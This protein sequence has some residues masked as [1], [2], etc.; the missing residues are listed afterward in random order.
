MRWHVQ[1]KVLRSICN[2]HQAVPAVQKGLRSKNG[3][4]LVNITAGY[5]S[6]LKHTQKSA[7][8]QFENMK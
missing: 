2:I 6:L 4:F 7:S 3:N 5:N 8:V 1:Q